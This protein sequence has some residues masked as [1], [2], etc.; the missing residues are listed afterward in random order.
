MWTPADDT[1][2]TSLDSPESLAHAAYDRLQPPTPVIVASPPGDQLV[3][4]PT[5]LW[6]DQW[7][8]V[9]ASASTPGASVAATATPTSVTWTTG[10]GSTVTC[11]GPGTPYTVGIDPMSTSPDCGHV[12][13][14]SSASMPGQTF[15]VT[16]TVHWTVT[17]S[18]AGQ[19]GTFPDMTTTGSAGFRVAES[20]A[21]NTSGG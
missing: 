19:D 9:S 6:I 10:D 14:R 21:L 15:P 18:G 3:N 5:W 8:P 20:Q 13:R 1:G 7:K 16:A 11:V 4:L 17:W 12:Y 2:T